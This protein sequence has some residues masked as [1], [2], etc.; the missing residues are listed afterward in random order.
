MANSINWGKIYETTYWGSGVADNTIN[1][2]KSYRD[3]AGNPA[4]FI[5]EWQTTTSPQTITI[6]IQTTNTYTINTSDGQ[7]ITTSGSNPTV[8]FPTAGTYEVSISGDIQ[9]ISFGTTNTSKDF[10]YDVKQWGTDT[11]WIDF[12]E[13]FLFCTNLYV[14]ASDVPNI[15]GASLIRAFRRCELTTFNS[16]NNW[17]VSSVENLNSIFRD[18][19]F[20]QDISNWD[21]SNVTAFTQAFR[22]S[23]FNQ[24]I[25][26]W[27]VSSAT[28]MQRM[29]EGNDAFDQDISGWDISNVTNFGNF[30]LNADGFSTDNY[31]ALLIGW[32]SQSVQNNITIDF[33]NSQYTA[34]GAAEAARNTLTTTYGWTIS[35][36]GSV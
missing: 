24:N 3:L 21:V 22:D 10:I 12:E 1:W 33:G 25:G 32:A 15:T 13:A 29:F 36:G 18:S 19:S 5:T 9:Q 34:G 2:G 6:P 17:D 28:E 11:T 16:V 27:D 35:D 14:S 4:P 20:N 30:M 31:D 7:E 8:T 26:N 23:P